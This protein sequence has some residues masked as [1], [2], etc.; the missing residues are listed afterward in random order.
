VGGGVYPVL[1][2]A[3]SDTAATGLILGGGAV[4]CGLLVLGLTVLAIRRGAKAEALERRHRQQVRATARSRARAAAA[5]SATDEAGPHD[6]YPPQ[7]YSKHEPKSHRP[8]ARPYRVPRQEA[9]G[10][11]NGH[12]PPGS[13]AAG[14]PST[15]YP[16]PEDEG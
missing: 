16:P 13:T 9:H 5:G 11:T 7:P 12:R 2:G 3:L 1:D 10:A 4:G 15:P 6:P 8:Y 14:L